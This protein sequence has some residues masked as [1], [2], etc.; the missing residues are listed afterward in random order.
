MRCHMRQLPQ[1]RTLRH[2]ISGHGRSGMSIARALCTY[3]WNC[4]DIIRRFILPGD[5][6]DFL[7]DAEFYEK[8]W[9]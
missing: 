5:G 9:R 8:Y 4:Y 1:D 6:I 3:Y 7:P 2:V